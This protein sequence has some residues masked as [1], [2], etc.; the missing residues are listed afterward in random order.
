MPPE[1]QYLNQL[2]PD[3]FIYR[4]FTYQRFKAML[5][6]K[7]L[8]LLAPRKWDDPFENFLSKIPAK[9]TGVNGLV[10]LGGIFKNYFGQ[11]WTLKEESDAIWRIYSRCKDGVKVR[12]TPRKLLTAIYD[13]SD[14]FKDMS[15]YVGKVEYLPEADLRSM[16]TGPTGVGNMIF[17]QSNL[18]QSKT[19]FIKRMEF[20]HEAEVRLLY[21]YSR[22][23]FGGELSDD[24]FQFQISPLDLF[25]E[26]VFDPRMATSKF[27]LHRDELISL[28][29]S[30]R[31]L[32]STL[33]RLPDFIV[34]VKL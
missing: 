13:N 19:L 8:T 5:L 27:K 20:E 14:P 30:N 34:E 4:V 10:S 16:L 1:T 24:I 23:G 11:C 28:G 3:A 12:T 29:F 31:I 33:Y 21:R 32:Q 6:E 25:D 15:Y 26:V 17:D 7:K 22:D 9:V 18:N 2:D